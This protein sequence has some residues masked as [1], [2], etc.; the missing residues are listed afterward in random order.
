MYNKIT[1]GKWTI[2]PLAALLFVSPGFAQQPQNSSTNAAASPSN[3]TEG[4]KILRDLEY[5]R[6]G[7]KKLLLDLYLPEKHEGLAPLIIWVHG[8]AWLAGDKTHCL[9]RRMTKRGYAV[10]SINYR[11]SSEAIFPAQ[12]E[13]CKAAVR[14]LRANAAQ[15]N[16]DPD[17]FGAWGDSAGG[18]LVALLGTT[19]NVKDFDRGANL[20]V[21]SQVQAVCDYFGP[22]DFLQMDARALPGAQLKHDLPSSPESLLIGGPIQ[23]NKD[24]TARANPITYITPAASPFLIVHGDQDPLVPLHQSQLLY[25]ALKKAGVDVHLHIIKGAG[26]GA[27]FGGPDIEQM[28]NNFFDRH[29]KQNN[30]KD[31]K[32]EATNTYSTAKV[33]P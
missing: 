25:D 30:A 12:I 9:A 28:V 21:S 22:T 7:Q 32:N 14:W 3:T 19:G 4:V 31:Q 5:G 27:G 16:L 17:R 33:R 2:V 15:Y 29:L 11:L 23:E 1:L 20:D 24:M 18:H 8:G 13:D 26:H 10:A 6:V